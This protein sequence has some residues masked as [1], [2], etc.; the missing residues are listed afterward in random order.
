MFELVKVPFALLSGFLVYRA[1]CND[2]NRYLAFAIIAVWLRLM[3][4]AFPQYTVPSLFAGFSVSALC[5]IMVASVGLMMLP[6]KVLLLRKMAAFYFVYVAIAISG[7][8]TAHWVGTIS[9][10]VKW[11]YFLVIA[12]CLILSIRS[13]GLDHSMKKLLV[14]FHLPI[15]L[16]ILSVL[17]GHYKDNESDG[18]VSYIGGYNHESTFSIILVAFMYIVG[19]I[20]PGAMRYRAPLFFLGLILLLLA[21]YRT[22]LLAVL[23]IVFIFVFNQVEHRIEKRHKLPVMILVSAGLAVALVAVSFLMRERFSDIWVLVSN[24]DSLVKAPVYYTEKEQDI[25]S[26]RVYIWSIY[27]YNYYAHG[28]WLN[29]L[30]G[31]GPESWQELFHRYAHNTFISYIYEYGIVGLSA[32]LLVNLTMIVQAFRVSDTHLSRT[33][34]YTLLGFMLM[35]MSTMPLWNVEGLI[36]YAILVATIVGAREPGW[37]RYILRHKFQQPANSQSSRNV[38]V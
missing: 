10:L 33:T 15:W 31:F 23:P 13:Q 27:L 7:M 5:S 4:A 36:F 8:L 2:C 37:E 14:A 38:H 19:V 16:Q 1:I 18:S 29:W 28:S 3:L 12:N 30:F 32:F 6:P 34:F 17:L 21:N 24:V 20:R 22:S 11:C 35:N 26:Q 9:V 25:L